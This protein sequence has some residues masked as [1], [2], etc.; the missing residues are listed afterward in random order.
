MLM[1]PSKHDVD[2]MAGSLG[3]QRTSKFQFPPAG[4]SHMMLA[5]LGFQQRVR[6]SLPHVSSMELS[7]GLHDRPRMPREWPRSALAGEWAFRRSHIWR[8]GVVSSSEATMTW[9]ATSGFQA[10][11]EREVRVAESVKEMTGRFCRRSH[12]T[13]VPVEPVEARMCSTLGFHA[14]LVMSIVGC[15]AWPGVYWLGAAGFW[16]SQMRISDSV[17]PDARRLGLKMLKSRPRTGPLC[18]CTLETRASPSTSFIMA[19]GFHK[20]MPPSTIPPARIP[21]GI[22]ALVRPPHA[23]R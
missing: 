14:T 21:Y 3:D 7:K 16:R 9:V 11:Q 19:A 20:P 13:E 10:M 4:S 2:R 22:E 5:V 17:E 12:T 6:L 8:M 18:F 1:E 15:V 23:N